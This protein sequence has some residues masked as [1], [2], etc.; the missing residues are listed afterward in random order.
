MENK[1]DIGDTVL[2]PSFLKHDCSCLKAIVRKVKIEESDFNKLTCAFSKSEYWYSLLYLNK[3]AE[4]LAK[5]YRLVII[6]QEECLKLTRIVLTEKF[7]D[8][9]N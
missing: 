3:R 4:E 1:F 9:Q 2:I 5:K 6:R 8:L 7:I